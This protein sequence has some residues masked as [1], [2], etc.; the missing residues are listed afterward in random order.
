MCPSNKKEQK[1][2][3][4]QIMKAVYEALQKHGYA[5]LTM[6]KIADETNKCKS[7]LHYHYN[8]RNELLTAFLEYIL[9][10]FKEKI[11][12]QNQNPEEKL[13][14][15]IDRLIYGNSE[16]NKEKHLTFHRDLLELRS[17]TPYNKEF[18]KQI[19]ENEKYLH[20]EITKT[21]KKG[22]KKGTFKKE[23]NPEQIASLI[24][25]TIDGARIQQIT[26][27]EEQKLDQTRRALNTIIKKTLIKNNKPNQTQN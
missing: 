25:A 17:Q 4:E 2:T 16:E 9:E 22:I 14:L 1:E 10:K 13:N 8:T 6:Q 11:E 20:Q 23:N 12:I 27:N 7:T 26:T 5:N 3:E 18:K 24:L 15:I 21:I 19:T